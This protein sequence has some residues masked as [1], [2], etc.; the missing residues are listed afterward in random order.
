MKKLIILI[1]LIALLA[2][3]MAFAQVTLN[4]RIEVEAASDFNK[5]KNAVK[6]EL[7]DPD[8]RI[9][10]NI[11]V[12][13]FNTGYIRMRLNDKNLTF[14]ENVRTVYFDRAVFTNNLLGA[15]GV[16]DAPVAWTSQ[17]GL[18]DWAP[19][20]V[21]LA[22]WDITNK[23]LVLK[24]DYF[25][26]EALWGTKQSFSFAKM[27]NLGVFIGLQNDNRLQDFYVDASATV[28]AGPGKLG[29]EVSYFQ[30]E[31][32]NI[33]N[34]GPSGKLKLGEGSMQ[35]A[36]G[37]D[38]KAGDIPVKLGGSYVL[39]L[40][41]EKSYS[42][43]AFNARATIATAYVLAGLQ[44]VMKNDDLIINNKPLE[45]QPLHNVRLAAGM[46]FTPQ[47]GADVGAILYTG[48]KDKV[49]PDD[50]EVFNTLDASVYVKAGK[51]TYRFGYLY[52]PEKDKSIDPYITDSKQNSFY[53][54]GSM[55]Y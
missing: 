5:D 42:A 19:A 9:E 33:G 11:K 29:V 6:P 34:L 25:F 8:V 55:A 37:Y 48:G 40:K 35:F 54:V 12:D 41:K 45:A 51:T 7:W 43:Y 26:A 31:N 1:S 13:D 22:G 16:K 10:A 38:M 49:G 23:L 39:P 24:N 28:P 15:M 30:W 27:V 53:F 4:G 21:A 14:G 46:A 36:V 44:G 32:A 17:L 18:N 3:G 2:S 50:R 52:V 20:N 47:L